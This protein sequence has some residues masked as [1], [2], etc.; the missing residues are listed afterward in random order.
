MGV[1]ETN[2]QELGQLQEG[3]GDNSPRETEQPQSPLETMQS[4]R[5]VAKDSS[6]E[7]ASSGSFPDGK[8]NQNLA[9]LRAQTLFIR[10]VEQILKKSHQTCSARNYVITILMIAYALTIVAG[11]GPTTEQN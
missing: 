3:K 7:K 4:Q 8:V 5:L 9:H 6:S 2:P 11:K 1:G 10:N